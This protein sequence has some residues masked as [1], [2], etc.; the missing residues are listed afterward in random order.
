MFENVIN[1]G[2]GQFVSKSNWKHPDII[3]DSHEMIFVTKGVVHINENEKNY[4]VKEN[5]IIILD[6]YVRHF[7]YK[8]SSNTEFYWLHWYGGPEVFFEY[9]YRKLE[10]SYNISVYLNQL[11]KYKTQNKSL[12]S[13]NYLTRLILIEIFDN[14]NKPN[15]NHIAEKTAAL[16]SAYRYKNISEKEI[17]NYLGYNSDYLNRLFKKNFNKTLKQYIIEKRLEYI[18]ELMLCKNYS[19][20]EIANLTGFSE[21]KY[22][23]KFFKYHEGITPTEFH[24]QNSQKSFNTK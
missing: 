19:L 23:L 17:S 4:S 22:F 7:G 21:Y 16:I 20:T 8:Y 14:S 3:I 5:E 15:I 9:K 18:K 10:N 13:L 6:P 2:I 24:K 1:C 12:E 11:I